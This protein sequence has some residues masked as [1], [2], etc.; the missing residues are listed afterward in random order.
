MDVIQSW[1][2][3]VLAGDRRALARVLTW[4]ENQTPEGRALVR[5]LF[6]HTGRAHLIGI[7]GPPGVG[8]STLVYALA[9]AYRR[10][11][12]GPARRVGVLAVDPSSPYT[13]GALLGDRIR[14]QGLA[15]DPGVFIR[16]M[17]SRGAVGGLARTTSQAA[18]VL[19]AAGYDVIFIETVGAGQAEVA[20]AR[21][22]HTVVVVQAPGLGDD[23]Q[24][25]KA[26]ILEIADI[27]VVNKGD[28]P[29]ALAAQ[30][31]LEAMLHLSDENRSQDTQWAP[32][33]L[34]T[35]ATSGEGIDALIQA[36]D[37]HRDFLLRS[38][39]GTR[40]EAERLRAEVLDFVREHLWDLWLARVP[41]DERATALASVL[42]RRRAPDEVA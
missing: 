35:T 18:H 22:A 28:R 26:G 19:D 29:D 21:L 10:P 6:P 5:A 16:S 13:G 2:Q 9:R 36:L 25:I 32:P 37:A 17:A 1:A 12:R 15:G 31:T 24:A 23:I 7:T 8:K 39:E 27:L 14:M 30:R 41:E 3:R 33:V 42:Q 38:G 11:A 40:R 20:I 34:L 4:V